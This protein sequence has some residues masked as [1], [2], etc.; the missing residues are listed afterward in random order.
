MATE[1]VV[2]FRCEACNMDFDS[3]AALTDHN[4]ELPPGTMPDDMVADLGHGD[5]K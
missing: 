4:V 5:S 1:Q 3:M 2:R